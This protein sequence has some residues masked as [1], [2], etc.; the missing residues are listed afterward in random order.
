MD[1]P[2]SPEITGNQVVENAQYGIAAVGSS[3]PHVS[4]NSIADNGAGLV[5]TW[6]GMT[7]GGQ[8]FPPVVVD[9]RNNWWGAASG[10]F[11]PEENPGG[12][13]NLVSN[14]V[15]FVPWLT[16]PPAP[17]AADLLAEVT[18]HL[19]VHSV[20][21][22]DL[23]VPARFSLPGSLQTDAGARLTQHMDHI[24]AIATR[25][26]YD[27]CLR[28]LARSLQARLVFANVDFSLLYQ[29]SSQVTEV[30]CQVISVSPPGTDDKSQAAIRV[31]YRVNVTVHRGGMDF[32]QS[33]TE[34]FVTSLLLCVPPGTTVQ[35]SGAG[36]CS[37]VVLAPVNP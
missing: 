37:S 3:N 7:I 26:V 15:D 6:E 21:D 33:V 11:H 20:A 1:P 36:A 29:V 31:S 19:L 4:W 16:E 22:V 35:C 12:Q 13:G 24:A 2:A 28:T 18:L 32:S 8:F 30:T 5:N 17:G 14:F 9:A 34:G 23:L 10:P 27:S 25:R